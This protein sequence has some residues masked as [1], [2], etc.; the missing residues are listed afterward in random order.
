M[1][2]VLIDAGRT[3][4][5]GTDMQAMLR[6]IRC[7]ACLN[8]C[9]VYQN[10]GGHAYGWVYPGPIGAIVTPLLDGLHSATPLPYASSLCGACK[11]ACPVD[12]DIPT[13]LL[14]LRRDLVASG[15]SHF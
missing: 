13:M 5:V 2:I 10:V 4:F 8:A 1:H 3:K 9:P 6:C 7:G 14:K 15:E 11:S 12:I